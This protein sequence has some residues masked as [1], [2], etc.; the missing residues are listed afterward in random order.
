MTI[1]ILGNFLAAVVTIG[2]MVA[3]LRFTVPQKV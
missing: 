2:M 1:L 3:T